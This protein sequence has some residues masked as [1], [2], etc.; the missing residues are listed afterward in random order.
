MMGDMNIISILYSREMKSWFSSSVFYV[1]LA[2]FS[3]FAMAAM[4]LLSSFI[5]ANAADLSQSFFRWHPWIFAMTAPVIG[6]RSWSEEGHCGMFEVMGTQ[7]VRIGDWV[8][9]KAL[10]GFT[11]VFIALLCTLPAVMTAAWLGDPDMGMIASGYIGS[12]LCGCAFV[13][14]SQAVCVFMRVSIGAFVC[15]VSLCLILVICGITQVANIIVGTFPGLEW[16]TDLLAGISVTSKYEPFVDGRFEF[17]ALLGSLL[18]IVTPLAISHRALLAQRSGLGREGSVKSSR[19]KTM[20]QFDGFKYGAPIAICVGAYAVLVILSGS[21]PGYID[22]TDDQ[23]FNLPAAVVEDVEALE[24]DV[25]VRLFVTRRHPQFGFDLM[26]YEKRIRETLTGIEKR[27]GGKVKFEVLDPNTDPEAARIA[28][29]DEVESFVFDN[30]DPF[31]FGLVVESLNKKRVFDSINPEREKYFI[32]DIVQAIFNV[33]RAD[34]KKISV[35]TPFTPDRRDE[36][37]AKSWTGFAALR[38]TYDVSYPL[39]SGDWDSADTVILFHTQNLDR[40][41]E[42]RLSRYVD[43]GGDLIVFTDPLSIVSETFANSGALELRSS[44]MPQF[45]QARGINISDDREIYDLILK[46]QRSTDQ[47]IEIDATVLTLGA[48]QFN[49]DHAITSGFDTVHFVHAGGLMTTPVEGFKN[50]TLIET[51]TYAALLDTAYGLEY[52]TS[53]VDMALGTLQPR[54]EPLPLMILQ[55]DNKNKSAGRVLYVSDTDWLHN[56]VAGVLAEDSTIDAINSNVGLMQN[57]I[58]YLMGNRSLRELRLRSLAKRPL[59]RWAAIKQD[60][61]DHYRE[62]TA[63]VTAKI[64]VLEEEIDRLQQARHLSS[65]QTGRS[66]G[67]E[68]RL[69]SLRQELRVQQAD[70]ASVR[71][72]REAKIQSRLLKIKWINVLLIPLLLTLFGM[73]ILARRAKAVSGK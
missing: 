2:L 18:L 70:L 6:I 53:A 14:I 19:L 28:A 1:Y 25:T 62:P 40:G 65:E 58:D 36:L 50:E 61:T 15:A 49:N 54:A 69:S 37:T 3:F 20:F 24:R 23:R 64:S 11:V 52:N 29:I 22:M 48:A 13:A 55:S 34:R 30:G 38:R 17:S 43:Q 45:L 67:I 66:S 35:L 47:G 16:V 56:A 42:E 46:T 60:I 51:S 7:P 31:M 57:M 26:R 4:F 73:I 33:S 68:S 27:S 9:A 39:P 12:F 21:M 63:E 41:L 8:I 59:H 72:E 5:E 32:A 10:A 71:N 44:E